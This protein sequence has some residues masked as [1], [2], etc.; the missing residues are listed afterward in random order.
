MALGAGF[1]WAGTVRSPNMTMKQTKADKNFI[2]LDEKVCWIEFIY[3]LWKFV[4]KMLN[5]KGIFWI[6]CMKFFVENIG[7]ISEYRWKSVINFLRFV[8]HI[9]FF[10][11]STLSSESLEMIKE[12]LLKFLIRASLFWRD[13]FC[14]NNSPSSFQKIKKK[15]IL[16]LILSKIF[17]F[18]AFK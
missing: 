16:K 1:D 14:W 12:F 10:P 2:F 4:L 17:H 7:R 13:R 9:R 15:F 11:N 6:N 8:K 5:W 18:Y 3:V